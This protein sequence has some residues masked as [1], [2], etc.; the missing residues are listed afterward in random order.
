[1][2]PQKIKVIPFIIGG[3][4]GGDFGD[5]F[6]RKLSE[7]NIQFH[8]VTRLWGLLAAGLASRI[9]VV[10]FH[11]PE[12]FLG[13]KSRS[14]IIAFIQHLISFGIMTLLRWKGI[15]FC[16]TAHN[17][18]PHENPYP[19]LNDW[20]FRVFAHMMDAIIVMSQWQKQEFIRMFKY[21]EKAARVRIIPLGNFMGHYPDSISKEAARK[22]LGI[23][24]DG[25]VYLIF[26]QI[27]RYKNI[28]ET[29]ATFKQ[30]RHSEDRLLVVGETADSSLRAEI[31]SAADESILLRLAHI[32]ASD[33]ATYFKAADVCLFPFE[34]VTNSASL[35]LAMSFG[36]PVIFKKTGSPQEITKPSFGILYEN[37]GLELA[38]QEIRGKDLIRMGQHALQEAQK[39]DWADIARN[40][41]AVYDKIFQD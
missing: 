1:M 9:Q 11:W 13:S 21:E 27:R 8:R 31:K 15:K 33:V 28:P 23:A 32:P 41:R 39:Y 24:P 12:Y 4:Y 2:T 22:Q 3:G 37:G 19:R 38:L 6:I 5:I 18:E 30:T 25:F 36:I 10:D 16:W 17:H 35:L 14:P 26:G 34:R 20:G 7:Q 29:L 40:Y